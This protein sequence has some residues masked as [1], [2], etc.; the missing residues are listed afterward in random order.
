MK[1]SAHTTGVV[2]AMLLTYQD[3]QGQQQ[4]AVAVAVGSTAWFEWLEQARTFTFRDASGRFT[5]EKSHAGNQRA[6]PTGAR[7]AATT[8]GSLA[9]TS[10][11][12]SA[13]LPSACARRRWRSPSGTPRTPPR[14]RTGS[15]TGTQPLLQR[16]PPRSPS[17]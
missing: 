1:D 6:S 3:E 9:I 2:Q 15:P 13:S 16:T 4:S 10:A 17:R 8:D 11:L 7:G 12:P 5:A 14:T